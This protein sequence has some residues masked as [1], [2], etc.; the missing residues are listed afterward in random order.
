MNQTSVIAGGLLVA[1]FIF[2]VR[3]GE[4]PCYLQVLGVA[5]SASC[6]TGNVSSNPS[7]I[8]A[9][10]PITVNVTGGTSV[11]GVPVSTG[12]GTGGGTGTGTQIGNNCVLLGTCTSGGSGNDCTFGVCPDGYCMANPTDTCGDDSNPEGD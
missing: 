8:C 4:L 3:R 6:P 11:V 2:V 5:T 1:Y 9:T 12:T 7:Q 10:A